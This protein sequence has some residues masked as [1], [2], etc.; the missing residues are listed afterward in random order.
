M[1]IAKCCQSFFLAPTVCQA[2]AEKG[3]HMNQS[4]LQ[5][6]HLEQKGVLVVCQWF[7]LLV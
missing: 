4:I 1:L 7:F 6:G 2:A 5:P 3:E